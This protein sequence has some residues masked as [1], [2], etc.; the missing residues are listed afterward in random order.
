MKTFTAIIRYQRDGVVMHE[1][2]KF[3]TKKECRAEMKA[4]GFRILAVLTDEEIER[5][6]YHFASFD[7][8]ETMRYEH[9]SN[10]VKAWL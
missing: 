8:D 7:L 4:N 3:N 6:K 1:R 2:A 9:V 5:I 10:Y